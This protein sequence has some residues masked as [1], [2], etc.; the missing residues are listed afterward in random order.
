MTKVFKKIFQLMVADDPLTPLLKI[1]KKD[2]PIG[3]LTQRQLIQ[4]ESDICRNI[5]GDLPENVI[6]REFFN[7]D[8][9]TWIWHEEVN[10][11][12]GIRQEITTRYEVKPQG[13]LKI[14]PGPRYA[15]LEGDELRNFHQAVKTY[16]YRV[17][18]TI[19]NPNL[20]ATSV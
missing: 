14:Q 17:S 12:N 13:I 8:E 16:F 1:S 19:Y 6:R 5:F 4:R 11:Q 20:N 3:E 7:L 18:T 9:K 10:D 2:K 15:Y